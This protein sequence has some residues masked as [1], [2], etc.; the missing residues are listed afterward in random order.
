MPL[1]NKAL[2]LPLSVR[3]GALPQCFPWLAV[4]SLQK[5][6]NQFLQGRCEH[7]WAVPSL[8]AAEGT[9]PP[10]AM[11]V[12]GIKVS[13]KGN[14]ETTVFGGRG[15][16]SQQMQHIL[17]WLDQTG[18]F[19]VLFFLFFYFISLKW[20]FSSIAIQAKAKVT[21]WYGFTKVFLKCI[22]WKRGDFQS[23]G[24][25]SYW[26]CWDFP[27]HREA[28]FPPALRKL[29]GGKKKKIS[30]AA[31][32]SRSCSYLHVSVERV[33]RGKFLCILL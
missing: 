11:P 3:A 25:K 4:N 29:C 9:L 21:G 15:Q 5:K 13:R 2:A 6:Q 18:C 28:R 30:G 32:L 23:L 20:V 33:G 17:F 19:K 1:A 26:N 7:V 8:P 22:T 24:I 27:Q 31:T 10:R 14:R 12:P 16:T